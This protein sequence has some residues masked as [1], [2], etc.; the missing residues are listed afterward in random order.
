VKNE[1]K[2]A[3]VFITAL[4]RFRILTNQRTN[5]YTTKAPFDKEYLKDIVSTAEKQQSQIR[6]NL[7]LSALYFILT[8]LAYREGG[9]ELSF[10]NAKISE[11]PSL[12]EIGVFLMSSSLFFS[13]AMLLN[14]EMLRE[15][16]ESVIGSAFPKDKLS[17][18]LVKYRY[19]SG[20]DFLWLF[21]NSFLDKAESIRPTFFTKTLNFLIRLTSLCIILIVYFLPIGFLL[22]YA[23][24]DLEQS[25]ISP[26]LKVF[27]WTCSVAF[28][29]CM[30]AVFVPLP[31]REFIEQQNTETQKAGELTPAKE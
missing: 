18:H 4:R 22:F 20:F 2:G 27:A 16:I 31:F 9:F 8:Y 7:K 26:F 17:Q 19:M 11:I 12:L 10:M 28:A 30:V 3:L 21:S 6:S 14:A 1:E 24:P 25:S 29:I 23:L 13:G 5:F 15:T